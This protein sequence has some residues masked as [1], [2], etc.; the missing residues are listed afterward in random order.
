MKTKR[1]KHT[2]NTAITQAVTYR[3]VSSKEQDESGF[4]LAAQERLL[5][6]YAE[7]HGLTVVAEFMDVET[8]KQSGRG[9]FTDMIKFMAEHHE[10]CRVV[11]VEKT[12]RLYRNLKDWVVI[13]DLDVDIHLVKEGTIISKES[14]SKSNQTSKAFMQLV[15]S[16]GYQALMHLGEADP[17]GMGQ[18]HVDLEAAREVIDLIVGLK[19][20]TQGNLSPEE[21]QLMESILP[22]LQMKYVSKS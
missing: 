16:L 14:G 17:S 8:A 3:R 9:A 1:A 5:R 22:E 6:E 2:S 19:E 11:L 18:S 21:N 15:T 4:S 12:D 20:K 10:T 7:R 13:D